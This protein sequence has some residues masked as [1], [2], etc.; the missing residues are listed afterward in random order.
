MWFSRV[1]QKSKRGTPRFFV[2]NLTGTVPVKY[3]IVMARKTIVLSTSNIYHIINRGVEK[4]DI[5][6]C[7]GDYYRFIHDLYEF[8]DMDTV[9]AIFRHNYTNP[10]GTVPVKFD[11]Y[12]FRF[13]K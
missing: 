1:I 11:F 10:T 3:S 13:E 6:T 8:N 5:F 4:R 9:D 12:E 7:D 2:Y